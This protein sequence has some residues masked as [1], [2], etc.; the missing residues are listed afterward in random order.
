LPHEERAVQARHRYSRSHKGTKG[1]LEVCSAST[2]RKN[3]GTR[4]KIKTIPNNAENTARCGGGGDREETGPPMGIRK[5][6]IL[7]VFGLIK[8]VSG[9]F[10]AGQLE[11]RTESDRW[12]RKIRGALPSFGGR[13]PGPPLA[14]L[15]DTPP[16]LRFGDGSRSPNRPTLKTTVPDDIWGG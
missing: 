16:T 3:Q 14:L 15:R 11:G 13:D 2:P 10:F 1:G 5:G 6:L 12:N 9:L 8:A 7:P 4:E